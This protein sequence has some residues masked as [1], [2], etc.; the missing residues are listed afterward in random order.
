[1]G[2]GRSLRDFADGDSNSRKHERWQADESAAYD[3]YEDT[4]E[5]Y[6]DESRAYPTGETGY[7]EEMS[8]VGGAL[9]PLG[10]ESALLPALLD[11][12]TGPVVIPGSGE[13]MGN[14]FIKR[15]ERPLTMRIAI[16]T[17][18]ACI[19]VTGLF[20]VTSLGS[21][22]DSGI[23]SFQAL[24]GVVVWHSDVGYYW[25]VA[26]WG[27]SV[28]TIAA[29]LHVQ[30]GGIYQLNDLL[31][32]Q[33]ITTGKAYKIPTDPNYGMN[34]Q[35]K[36]LVVTGGSSRFGNSPWTSIAGGF[37]AEASCGPNGSG[38]P[39]AYGL[40]SPNYGAAWIR[41]F[42]WFHNGVDLAANAGNPIH[43]AQT[44]QVIWAGWDVGGLGFSVKIDH[45]NGI[46]TVYG[47]MMQLNVTAGQNVNVGDVIGLEGSTG[48]STG[49]HCHFMVEVNNQP[50]DPMAYYGY[51]EYTITN[52]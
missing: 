18:V 14:P 50:V 19:L 24:S 41:G 11:D 45:C 29:A 22:A 46:S 52:P 49:P 32:G 12:E 48:W 40:K 31:L 27:D 7:S 26:K 42:S 34:F 5:R 35:P 15:R 21:N 23:T 9:V 43:A 3:A 17:L 2:R 47:H 16:L 44:G 36:S 13:S 39:T 51:N 20:A 4:G 25:Y 37:T 6:R 10:D 1:V 8:A 38:N 28:D 33:E 30:I